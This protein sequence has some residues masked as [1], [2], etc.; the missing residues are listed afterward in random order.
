MKLRRYLRNLLFDPKRK[1]NER[2]YILLLLV[3]MGMLVVA[4]VGDTIYNRNMAEVFTISGLLIVVPAISFAGIKFDKLDI[5]IKITSMIIMIVIPVIFF[6]AGG[7]EGAS[8]LWFIFYY[9]Y[10]GLCLTGWWRTVNLILLTA[11]VGALFVIEYL[12]PEIFK[13]YTRWVFYI[14]TSLAVVEIGFVAF[15]MT[16]FQNRQFT[17]EN[18]RAKE[19][20]RKV[21]ELNR[22][23]NRFFSNMSHEI[24]TPINSILGLNEIILRQEDVSEEI[25]QDAENIQGAGRMLLTLINDILDFSKLEAGRMDIV[26]INY[27]VSAMLSEIVNM[28]WLRAQQKGLE[29][30]IEVDP[31]IPSELFGDE[32]RI[33]QIL[34]NLLNNAVKYTREGSVTLRIEKEDAGMDSVELV[35]SVIDTGVGI[36]NDAIPYLFDAFQRVDEQKNVGIEGT[37]LGLSIVKQLV[38]LMDGRITVNSVYTQGSTFMVELWQKVTNSDGVG[39]LSIADLSGK[40]SSGGYQPGFRAEDTKIL[41]VDDNKINLKVEKKLL[42]GTGINIDTVM[43]GEEALS[44]TLTVRYDLILMDHLMPVMDGIECMQLIRKQSGGLNN[45][46]PIV[47]LTANA[48]SEDRKLYISSGFD[49]YLVKPVSGYQLE[50][51]VLQHLPD[52]KVVRTTETAA[53]AGYKMNTSGRYGHKIPVLIAT[54]STC[55]IPLTVIEEQQIDTIPYSIHADDRIFYDSIEAG[56]DEVL[57]YM[58]SGMHFV[59][60]P[61][62]VAEFESFFGKELKKAHNVIYI[63][64]SSAM[65]KEYKNAC[66]AAGA[67]GNVTVVDAGY[68]TGAVGLLVLLAHRM[69]LQGAMPE[70][71]TEELNAYKS[72]LRCS[73]ITDDSYFTR[74]RD[75]F[76]RVVHNVVKIMSIRP[77]V[78]VDNGKYNLGGITLGVDKKHNYEK[79]IDHALPR[80]INPDLDILMVVYI[81]QTEEELNRI[82]AH[83][84]KRY[85]F[86]N[87]IFEKASATYALNSGPD[88][89]AIVYFIKGDQGLKLSQILVSKEPDVKD[90]FDEP[91][92]ESGEE[93]SKTT[94]EDTAEEITEE[95]TEEASEDIRE[96][97]HNEPDEGEDTESAAEEPKWY[98]IIPGING[99]HALTNC[100][101]EDGVREVLGIFY[102]SIAF[103]SDEIQGFYDNEDWE[104]YTIKVHALKSSARIIGADKLAD[105]ALAMENAGKEEDLKYIREHNEELLKEYRAYSDNLAPLFT[106]TSEKQKADSVIIEIM[107][108][109]VREAVKKR[110]A[111]SIREAF[112]E[113]EQ[114][115]LPAE[116]ALRLEQ[117]KDSLE[118]E[119]YEGMS[120]VMDI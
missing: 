119:D 20:T 32:V 11:M 12:H 69:S 27:S 33:K 112:K 90:V 18:N 44:M 46:V 107:Y 13:P 49:G 75:F 105:D 1:I 7:A 53:S 95:I 120:L 84:R 87:I 114:Y 104:N 71:I 23:Q 35:F 40:K 6:Q 118:N 50:E 74:R 89:L 19:E 21:E 56:A 110:D 115:E 36:K 42:D 45:H 15:I 73:F 102:D 97:D 3:A 34:I 26:P 88:S 17:E 85:E 8:I 64:V 86:E 80:F 28:L 113:I 108:D 77:F 63:A 82:E 10:I 76:T 43:S 68:I 116:D 92:K 22:S 65:N 48:G 52:S 14:D 57:R 51:C 91:S 37:G 109:T 39:E 5:M 9:L 93:V 66:E 30:K 29:F 59:S 117:L 54:N 67:Y 4:L 62:S 38:E 25:L 60:E 98:E 61:P 16:W 2:V 79:Y 72:R 47:V 101:E 41:I 111:A 24:R 96:D 31:T 83:I 99:E 106:G 94:S 55:D 103:K 58:Q 100:G 70:K 78:D 81:D